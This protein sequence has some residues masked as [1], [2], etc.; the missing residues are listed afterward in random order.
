MNMNESRGNFWLKKFFNAAGRAELISA[1]QVL[2][3]KLA[4]MAPPEEPGA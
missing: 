3:E 4:N 1:L 2:S